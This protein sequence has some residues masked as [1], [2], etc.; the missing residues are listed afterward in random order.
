MTKCCMCEK[1]I[2]DFTTATQNPFFHNWWHDECKRLDDEKI[3]GLLS[4]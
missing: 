4:Q 1:P 3:K 2:I